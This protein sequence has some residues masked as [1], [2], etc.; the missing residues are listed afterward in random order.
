[1]RRAPRPRTRDVVA[2]PPAPPS[3]IRE[4]RRVIA[5]IGIDRYADW[6]RLDNAV[7]DARGALALFQ[8]Y[9]F[10]LPHRRDGRE[11]APLLDEAATSDAIRTLITEELEQ[12]D[13]ADSL[14]VFFAGHGHSVPRQFPDLVVT[15]GYMI[16]ADGG[17]ESG[18]VRRWLRV[19]TLLS[20]IAQ[21][22]PRHILVIL[23][24]CNSGIA[25]QSPNSFVKLRKAASAG[26]RDRRSRRV[27]TSARDD[28]SARDNGPVPG[29][30][31]F[32]G[33]L[34]DGFATGDVAPRHENVTGA[35][36]GLYL[37]RRVAA[38]TDDAQTPDCGAFELDQRGD[39]VIELPQVAPAPAPEV[40]EVAASEIT[41]RA[42]IPLAHLTVALAGLAVLAIGIYGSVLHRAVAKPPVSV[43]APVADPC[44]Q[45]RASILRSN[46]FLPVNSIHDGDALQ[47]YEVS[48]QEWYALFNCRPVEPTARIAKAYITAHEAA[49]FCA[50]LGG[51]LP[52]IAIWKAAFACTTRR[53]A[54]RGRRLQPVAAEGP[55]RA[56]SD[57]CKPQ[58]LDHGRTLREDGTMTPESCARGALVILAILAEPTASAPPPHHAEPPTYDCEPGTPDPAAKACH[59]PDGFEAHVHEN[60]IPFCRKLPRHS[61]P[62]GPRRARA[63]LRVASWRRV[64]VPC[65]RDRAVMCSATR[66]RCPG[67]AVR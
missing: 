34:I 5:A 65:A 23:D 18:G 29:H 48:E 31:V 36:I 55:D 6:P 59:C 46:P 37:Q 25:L 63:V 12:L 53:D 4:G 35:E 26:R 45:A 24:A 2:S 40:L 51:A 10:E 27:I 19:D 38:Y 64:S 33:C 60:K 42:A 7:N 21:L 47:T 1:L 56:A 49:A 11:V 30:S 61:R 62:P 32:T 28:Q 22:P 3:P 13:H 20:E 58:R 67:P 54:P 17:P 44:G 50:K 9:G 8:Q 52:S 15:T 16:P 66:S 39:L 43:A 14:I 57:P 41:P